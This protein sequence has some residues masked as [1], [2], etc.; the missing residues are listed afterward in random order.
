MEDIFKP[1]SLTIKQLF[2][3]TDSLY[4]IP[5]YQ[6][7][8][9]WG[10]D[11][12][13]K[14]WEDLVE[15]KENDP[16][17]FLGSVITAKPEDSS[18]YLDIVDGQ[19][20]LTTL[21]ILLC[22]YRDLYPNINNEI[23]D[24]DPFAVDHKVIYSSIRFN[25]RF[26][27]LRLRTHS[28]HQSDFDTIILNGN[29][30]KVKK[31][32]KVDL[33]KDEPKFKFINTAN[34]FT[35]KLT[36][37]GESEA[38]S[39]IN[40]IFNS[41]KII[42]IDCQSVAFAIKLFQVLNDRG[43]DLSNSD[44]IKSFLIGQIQKSF[45]GDNELKKQK[46][47]QFMDDWKVCETHSNHTETTLND[48]FVMYEYY[49]LG[50]NPKKSLYDELVE[51][52]KGKDSNTV[53]NDVKSFISNYKTEI[54]DKED[55]LI[56]SY[57]YI[58]WG[59]YWRTVLLTALNS[60]YPQY[61]EF[62][63][64]FRR[65][66]YLSWIAG[67]TLTRIKQTSF[68]LIKWI[69]EGQDLDFIKGELESNMNQNET[70]K[71]AIDN[72]KGDIYFE[73]WCKPLLFMI[74]YQQTDDSSLNFFEMSDRNIQVEH[75]LPRA[76]KNNSDWNGKIQNPVEVDK[77]I[78]TGAN[79]TLLSGKKNQQASNNGFESKIQSYRGKG[80]YS[81]NSDG[82]TSFRIT[83][84]IVNDWE[85]NKF[86]KEWNLS[87]IEDRW[88]WFCSQVE[89]ILEIDLTSIKNTTTTPLN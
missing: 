55:K 54:F 89:V 67:F 25:D 9:S 48:L 43:L 29:T 69:K 5:R 20:R 41:V 52:F 61:Q 83:Q 15:A 32:T 6:R 66:Y 16:N 80:L 37:L 58:T 56:Y 28:N 53:I 88:Q 30:T 23:L 31:P 86:D 8:Y 40:Y 71:R 1:S 65:Y 17:Y 51:Q 12:L 22:V 47:D 3:N 85:N 75:I 26:E 72:L 11:Q 87:S 24:T 34:F 14:L 45:A 74:E 79:L 49:V 46:E 18:S 36:E 38:G 76:Y 78:N 42:R 21:T 62:I 33:R 60:N 35:N 73:S 50:T 81:E 84:Q 77:W 70:I 57:F 19:Q 10:D 59:M 13:D 39:L 68:N 2:G 27:R 82:I 4:Q 63:R 64:V 7:P 44:L